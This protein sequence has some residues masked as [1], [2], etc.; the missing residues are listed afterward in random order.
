LRDRTGARA[1]AAPRAERAAHGAESRLGRAIAG[2]ITASGLSEPRGAVL[3]IGVSHPELLEC[4]ARASP[5]CT[6]V[7]PSRRAA[8]AA[9][10]CEPGVRAAEPARGRRPAR[11]RGGRSASGRRRRGGGGRGRA[12]GM[13]DESCAM[14][15]ESGRTPIRVSFEFFP[16]ADEAMGAML[17]KSIERLAPL[18]PRFVSVTY[19]ADGSTRERT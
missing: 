2:F 1:A 11:A 16:P 7:A 6:A 19:G 4:A 5:R 3:V 17:W 9:R 8:Q 10:G 14:N 12:C 15:A 13:S 18:A